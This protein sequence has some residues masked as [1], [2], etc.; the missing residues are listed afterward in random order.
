MTIPSA[1]LLVVAFIVFRSFY[2]LSDKKMA[3][4]TSKLRENSQGKNSQE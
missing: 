1:L 2:R 3:E 4:V